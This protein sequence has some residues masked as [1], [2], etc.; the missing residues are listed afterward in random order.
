MLRGTLK[1][2]AGNVRLRKEHVVIHGL[3]RGEKGEGFKKHF[4]GKGGPFPQGALAYSNGDVRGQ[5]Q[6]EQGKETG[7]PKRQISRERPGIKVGQNRKNLSQ[8][9][10]EWG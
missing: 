4:A 6:G 1:L 7:G 3:T 8:M 2:Q 10:Q 9:P 5:I